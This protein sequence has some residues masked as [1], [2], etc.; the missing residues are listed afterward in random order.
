MMKFTGYTKFALP[1]FQI[2]GAFFLTLQ[3]VFKRSCKLD[4]T[5]Y[6]ICTL[7][8]SERGN[9]S[10]PPVL[11]IHIYLVERGSWIH[12]HSLDGGICMTPQIYKFQ[13][14]NKTAKITNNITKNLIYI[15]C[16]FKMTRE[17]YLA[18][19]FTYTFWILP[20]SSYSCFNLHQCKHIANCILR[21]M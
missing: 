2:V 13:F 11:G 10:L 17:G 3:T 6:Q 9:Q 18:W 21:K 14:S 7:T 5:P 19:E 1:R 15:T 16:T 4:M 20:C 12:L 8:Q